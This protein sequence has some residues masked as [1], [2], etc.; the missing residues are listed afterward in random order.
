[1]RSKLEP[2]K[3]IARML[4]GH[5]EL[6][7]NLFRAK[8]Q[9]SSGVV[10]GSQHEGQTDHQKSLRLSNLSCAAGSGFVS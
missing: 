8:D 1:M 5:R 4:G 3:K 6:L 7:L 2:M 10:E 9:L